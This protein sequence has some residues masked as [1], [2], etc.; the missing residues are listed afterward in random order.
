M[1]PSCSFGLPFWGQ[2]VMFAR[3]SIWRG[4]LKLLRPAVPKL[5]ELIVR[6]GFAQLGWLN[7]FKNSACRLNFH[8]SPKGTT[9][10]RDRSSFQRCG[11]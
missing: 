11:P 9:L 4:P 7:T 2:K 10:E 1:P 5:A 3:S 6:P 8:R